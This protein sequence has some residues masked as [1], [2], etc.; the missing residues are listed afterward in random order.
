MQRDPYFPYVSI[1]EAEGSIPCE[2]MEK[3]DSQHTKE[4]ATNKTNALYT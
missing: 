4:A 3:L 1:V 2:S